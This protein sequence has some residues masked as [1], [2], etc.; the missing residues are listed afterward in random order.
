[1]LRRCAISLLLTAMALPALARTRPHYGGVL[2]V[3]ITGDPWRG[4]DGLARSLAFDGLTTLDANGMLQPALAASWQSDGNDH[5]WDLRLRPGVHF[6]DGSPLTATAVVMSLNLA[7]MGN[8]PW[9]AVRAAGTLSL[10]FTSDSPL[11]NLPALLAGNAFLIALTRNA[12]GQTPAQPIG[13]GPFQVASTAGNVL[14]LAA[15]ENC[16]QG[17]PFADQIVVTSHRSIHDQW[18][19]LGVGRAD[20]VEVPAEQ[21][22]QAQQQRLTVVSS[23]PVRLLALAVSDSGTLANPM[24][25]AAIAQAVDRSATYNVIFQK[26]GEI[27]ASLLPQSLTGYAFLFPATRDLNKA[28]ELRGGLNPLPLMLKADGNGAIELTAQRLALNLREAG[29]N[30]QIAGNA[31]RADLV[32]MDLP[33]AGSDPTGVLASLLLNAGQPAAV[34]ARNPEAL[35]RAEHD[36]LE[37]HT[38]VP[39]LNLP[40][41]YAVGG[42][43]HNF[44]LHADGTPDLASASVEEAP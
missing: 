10:I 5:R 4:E 31:Q 43:L 28:N 7:C 18:L 41:A 30:V 12:D 39:L 6:H 3:E 11:P 44:A 38:I 16:W 26:Q 13:T 23:P 37:L 35:F 24:L 34:S 32:L 22:R 19:D 1:V 20:V 40:R 27:T 8:C 2:H 42:R 21:L 15:N 9:K 25:R 33:I 14:T 29:F 36:F 17:R